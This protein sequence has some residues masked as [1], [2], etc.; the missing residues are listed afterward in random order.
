MN[1][2]DNLYDVL[3]SASEQR[4]RDNFD[5]FMTKLNHGLAD[6]LDKAWASDDSDKYNTLVLN[7]KA[8]GVRVFRN[9][10]GKHKL[11]YS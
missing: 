3:R 7:I 2:W 10:D 8:Q 5:A 9:S 6:D 11:K 1:Q 4:K